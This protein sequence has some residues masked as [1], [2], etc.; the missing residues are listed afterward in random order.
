MHTAG[1]Q[2]S[3]KT[4]TSDSREIEKYQTLSIT[5]DRQ[6]WTRNMN[7]RKTSRQREGDSTVSRSSGPGLL[8]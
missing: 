2:K 7:A 5:Y 8:E 6:Y 4:D 1:S 3:C